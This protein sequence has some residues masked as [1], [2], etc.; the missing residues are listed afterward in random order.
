MSCKNKKIKIFEKNLKNP[1]HLRGVSF[2]I[3]RV[4]TL[5]AM[6]REVAALIAGFPWS[7]CQVKKLAT[8]HCIQGN[9]AANKNAGTRV[10]SG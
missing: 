5:I 3:T 2:I 6:K 1:L 4:V 10:E 9:K 7:E 8:S